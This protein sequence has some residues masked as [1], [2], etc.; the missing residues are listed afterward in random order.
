[1]CEDIHAIHCTD[2]RILTHMRICRMRHEGFRCRSG[3]TCRTSSAET[4]RCRHAAAGVI[5][6][7]REG[8]ARDVRTI[9]HR[10]TDLLIHDF[11]RRGET[12]TGISAGSTTACDGVQFRFILGSDRDNTGLRHFTLLPDVCFRI[13]R[14]R[15]RACCARPS[16]GSGAACACR[17]DGRHVF[18]RL[19]VHM[20]GRSIRERCAVCKTRVGVAL[21]GLDIDSRP[22]A[23]PCGEGHAAR[24]TEEFRGACRSYLSRLLPRI[25]LALADGGISGL[26]DDIHGDRAGAGELRGAAREADSDGLGGL[27]GLGGLVAFGSVTVVGI[28]CFDGDAVCGDGLFLRF[29]AREAGADCRLVHHDANGCAGRV[30]ADRCTA[31]ADGRI[32]AILGEDGERPC[33]HVIGIGNMGIGCRVDPVPARREGRREF[34]RTRARRHDGLDLARLVCGDRELA[35]LFAF[36]CPSH[37]AVFQI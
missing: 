28:V 25:V 35:R 36:R 1:M 12:D 5:C 21:V 24:K 17:R 3:K 2:L 7:D 8:I 11:D 32:A 18:R 37:F 14:D 23:A 26:V 27:G 15:V 20:R 33:L 30:S 19:R 22:E 29:I 13:G 6:F 9:P 10:G 34:A 31:Y 16:E 4:S